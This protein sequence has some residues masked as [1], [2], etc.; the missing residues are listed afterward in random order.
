[1]N[2]FIGGL[3]TE[4]TGLNFPENAATSMD[5]C[6]VS[7]IGDVLRR[8]GINFESNY[9]LNQIDVTNS[10]VSYYRWKNAG[11]DG[12]TEIFVLQ[13]GA[14]LYFFQSSAST[15]TAPL[16]SQLLS[17]T[18]NVSSFLASGSSNSVN[19]IECQ[20]SDGNGY[21][22]VYHPYCDP[23]YCVYSAGT[24]TGTVIN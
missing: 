13:V 10:A 7:I 18:V 3:K 16:S 2:N 21:L 5:N 22:F 1:M 19:Q 15:I 14:T 24:I 20:Y 6:V 12:E 23:F 11:G 17:S 8:E 9:F 4:F